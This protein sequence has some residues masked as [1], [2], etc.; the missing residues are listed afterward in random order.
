[1]GNV[2]IEAELNKIEG[3]QDSVI[4]EVL[5][6]PQLHVCLLSSSAL[7]RAG[8]KVTFVDDHCIVT[9]GVTMSLQGRLKDGIYLVNGRMRRENG[10]ASSKAQHSTAHFATMK[11]EAMSDLVIHT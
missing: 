9:K 1:M 5:S 10:P 7:Y 8:H 6:V 2:I 4:Y 11:N 3:I